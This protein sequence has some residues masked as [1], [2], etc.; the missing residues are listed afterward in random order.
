[1]W[2]FVHGVRSNIDDWKATPWNRIDVESI[3]GECKKI[4][5]DMRLMDKEV[6]LW[7][8][9]VDTESSLKN[10]MT[11]LRAITELQNPAIRERHWKELM[12]QTQVRIEITEKTT[13]ADLVS[14]NLHLFEE[15]I[16][17]I[18]D[19]SVKEGAM[20]KVL[21]DLDIMWKTM[22]FGYEKHMRTGL[23]L[24]KTTEEMME[25]LE[26]HQG[27]LQNML[28]SKYIPHFLQEVSMW[29]IQLSNAD[30]VI[31]SWF[32]VQRKWMYLESI[33]IGSKDIRSQLPAD[34]K[35]F[36]QIDSDF[37]VNL[38]NMSFVKD[39]I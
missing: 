5:K 17:N 39:F 36:D 27:Q 34:S 4:G 7:D 19:K 23:M 9:Y 10:L 11:S 29:Q 2:D 15:D 14:L 31:D 20:E 37:K 12:M 26:D 30:A 13:L 28:S 21:K 32:E 22:N 38:H 1:M 16:K 6:R 33:F 3:D 18:A 8:P 24:L 25:I 35:R